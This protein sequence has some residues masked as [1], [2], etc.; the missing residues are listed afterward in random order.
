MLIREDG[1]NMEQISSVA[2]RST[3]VNFLLITLSSA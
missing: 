2:G 1:R 3:T